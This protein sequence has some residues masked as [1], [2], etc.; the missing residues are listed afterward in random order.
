MRE[1]MIYKCL[2]CGNEVLVKRADKTKDG[3]SCSKCK[4]H[5]VPNR[6]A[7]NPTHS[8]T[9]NTVTVGI[10]LEGYEKMKQQLRNLE[11]TYDRIIEKQKVIE[12]DAGPRHI[13]FDIDEF[14]KELSANMQDIVKAADKAVKQLGEC[15]RRYRNR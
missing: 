6:Y 7:D 2:D 11:A 5:L 12:V 13:G 1:D 15:M 9:K 8:K 4:G 10:E 14:T 3:Q